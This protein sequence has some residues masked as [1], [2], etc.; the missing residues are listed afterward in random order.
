MKLQR[1]LL[2]GIHFCSLTARLVYKRARKSLTAL[3]IPFVALAHCALTRNQQTTVEAKPQLASEHFKD[4]TRSDEVRRESAP[5]EEDE[6][7]TF[8]GG[9]AVLQRAKVQVAF[10]LGKQTQLGTGGRQGEEADVNETDEQLFLRPI[11]KCT[12]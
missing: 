12:E 2:T 10:G 8:A 1:P 11:S 6:T 9:R 7:K 3:E 4:R 5:K